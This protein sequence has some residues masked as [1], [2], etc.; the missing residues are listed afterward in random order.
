M[1]GHSECSV[2]CT[3]GLAGWPGRQLQLYVRKQASNCLPFLMKRIFKIT[4]RIISYVSSTAMMFF[5][6]H[7][8]GTSLEDRI[9]NPS[10]QVSLMKYSDFI[11]RKMYFWTKRLELRL[12][13][14]NV[15]SHCMAG[16]LK[17]LPFRFKGSRAPNST[18]KRIS[19]PSLRDSI[20]VPPKTIL[21]LLCVS[22]TFYSYHRDDW[23]VIMVK[24]NYKKN[25]SQCNNSSAHDISRPKCGGCLHGG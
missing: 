2:H 7:F 10:T 11:V 18:V 25:S 3:Q 16:V 9:V 23:C 8:S 17:N 22:D 20:V 15:K 4:S 21:L 14:D 24:N 12:A 19:C 1:K 5:P 6:W 13:R